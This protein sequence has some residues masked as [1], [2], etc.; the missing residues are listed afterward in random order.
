MVVRIIHLLLSTS[1]VHPP[2]TTN[3]GG[4]RK[5]ASSASARPNNHKAETTRPCYALRVKRYATKKEFFYVATYNIVVKVLFIGRN[6]AVCRLCHRQTCAVGI[7]T[8]RA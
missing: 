7:S 6:P 1:K 2:C 4:W 8:S 3:T 5:P